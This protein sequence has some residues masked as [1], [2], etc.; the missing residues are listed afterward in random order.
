MIGCQGNDGSSE[1]EELDD[2]RFPVIVILADADSDD[3]AGLEGGGFGLH[4]FH[5]E[6]ARFIHPLGVDGLS[7]SCGCR[8]QWRA[9]TPRPID[10]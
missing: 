5:G 4:P 2:V 8:R 6:F 10:L 9:R 1:R 7:T 3:V